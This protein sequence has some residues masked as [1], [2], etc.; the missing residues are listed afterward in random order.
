MFEYYKLHRLGIS[1]IKFTL[2]LQQV[3]R[4]EAS[5]QSEHI[6]Q[7]GSVSQKHL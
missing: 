3:L 5:A 4:L 7:G 1:N 2:R 6:P